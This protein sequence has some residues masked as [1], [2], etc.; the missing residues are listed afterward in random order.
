MVRW[1][2]NHERESYMK[3]YILVDKTMLEANK[4]YSNNKYWGIFIWMILM[5]TLT[6]M[7]IDE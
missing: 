1:E 7:V 4:I 6:M 5:L 2:I 3:N